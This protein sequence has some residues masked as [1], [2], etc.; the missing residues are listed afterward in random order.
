MAGLQL[1]WLANE[2][3]KSNDNIQIDL[4]LGFAQF[5]FAQFGL[6]IITDIKTLKIATSK[7]DFHCYPSGKFFFVGGLSGETLKVSQWLAKWATSKFDFRKLAKLIQDTVLSIVFIIRGC[8][9]IMSANF[10]GFH[11]PPPTVH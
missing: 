7:L 4:A 2:Y 8:P 10:G 9:H 5:G 1:I 3:C 11:T 6:S